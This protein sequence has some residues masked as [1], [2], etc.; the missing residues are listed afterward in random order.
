MARVDENAAFWA[1]Y[2]WA[3]AGEEWSEG[4]GGSHAQWYGVILPR[5]AHYLPASS[6]LEIGPGHGRWT[7]YLREH[8]TSLA[9]VDLDEACIK[10][11]RQRFEEDSRITCH[12]NDGM[13]LAMIDDESVDFAFSFDSL[14][15]ADAEVLSSYLG[16]LA[17]TLAPEG[18]GF[19]HHSNAGRYRRY[20]EFQ[21]RIPRG[22]ARERLYALRFLDRPRWRTLDMTAERFRASCEAAGLQCI[23]Q[24][25]I[26]WTTR[27]LIDCFSTFTRPSS[28][29]ARPN[30]ILVNR[31]FMSEAAAIKRRARLYS[32]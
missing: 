28:R 4:W 12:V 31:R 1:G 22:R 20:F 16:E 7:S 21:E 2:D 14:V 29:W 32:P 23:S 30:R 26:P 17:R 8:C 15:H 24:E 3:E 5:I 6:M 19:V 10:A 9:I 27:R 11:C 25:V 13:S 18:V